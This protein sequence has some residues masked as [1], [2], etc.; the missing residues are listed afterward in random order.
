MGDLLKFQG[1]PAQSC[2]ADPVAKST[3]TT[4]ENLTGGISIALSLLNMWSPLADFLG[5]IS[6][7]IHVKNLIGD[8]R[9]RPKIMEN[10]VEEILLLLLAVIS[11]ISL[12]S[13]L[14]PSG[15]ILPLIISKAA[16]VFSFT[17]F[18]AAWQPK[19]PR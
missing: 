5:I 17:L 3:S 8:Q 19:L 4:I 15:F 16:T 14:I 12:M 6:Y 10:W 13:W 7:C 2:Q 11:L 18:S 9:K 1:L